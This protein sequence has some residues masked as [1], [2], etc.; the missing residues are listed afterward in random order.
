VDEPNKA[1]RII[2][3]VAVVYCSAWMRMRSMEWKS[4]ASS[5]FVAPEVSL[6]RLGSESVIV[7]SCKKKTVRSCQCRRELR[8]RSTY[9]SKCTSSMRLYVS[10]FFLKK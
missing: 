8:V 7:T 1:T 5:C 9:V 10:V 2:V 4:E 6:D 3:V